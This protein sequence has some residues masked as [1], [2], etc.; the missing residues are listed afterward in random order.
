[1]RVSDEG[2]LG[3]SRK[4]L[5]LDALVDNQTLVFKTDATKESNNSQVSG[6]SFAQR[7]WRYFLA[8]FRCCGLL[9]L[10]RRRLKRQ[11]SRVEQWN[12]HGG[13]T[14]LDADRI[15]QPTRRQVGES[16]PEDMCVG[17]EFEMP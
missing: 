13:S 15:P 17:D 4:Q 12:G 5:P 1:M 16:G 11:Q 3:N 6:L 8:V 2:T 7:V 14:V 9:P 10:G